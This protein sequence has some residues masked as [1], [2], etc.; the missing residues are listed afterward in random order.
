M[1]QAG[2]H[3][4]NKV[5]PLKVNHKAMKSYTKIDTFMD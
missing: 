1:L 4:D 5:I 2:Q 3:K